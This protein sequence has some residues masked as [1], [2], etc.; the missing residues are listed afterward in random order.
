MARRRRVWFPGAMYHVT[1]RGNRKSDIFLDDED[2]RTYL[3]MLE[4]VRS[5]YLF[6]LHSYCL[7]TNHVHLL[8]ETVDHPLTEIMK[9]LNFHY[10]IYFNKRHE[11]VGHV[12]QDRYG[13]RL[14]DDLHHFV[15][16][17]R[18]IHMNPVE[19][20]M[21]DSP[22]IYPWSS[23]RAFNSNSDPH[24]TTAKLLSNFP[25]PQIKNYQ[26][27]VLGL[28]PYGTEEEIELFV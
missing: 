25:E 8:L 13:A 28:P 15:V 6:H 12:F 9:M 19:A 10:A 7:M 11:L 24:V 17:S 18:Y 26:R 22:E 2:F 20:S 5:V 23:Y 16:S 3:N 1:S 21:V 27:F 14:I 4:E